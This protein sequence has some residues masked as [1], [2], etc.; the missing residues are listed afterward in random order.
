M[1]NNLASTIILIACVAGAFMAGVERAQAQVEADGCIA[2]LLPGPPICTNCSGWSCDPCTEGA[3]PST[4]KFCTRIQ[5]PVSAPAGNT[6][7]F[8][9]K[10]PCFKIYSC[11]PLLGG[12]CNLT[13]NVCAAGTLQSESSTEEYQ[14]Q[15]AGTCLP[16]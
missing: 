11:T 1:R 3:C 7:A 2:F 5:N 10:R 14:W 12:T 8:R 16:M 4:Y 9:E 6:I 13:N 15:G